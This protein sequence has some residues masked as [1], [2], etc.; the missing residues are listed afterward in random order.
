MKLHLLSTILLLLWVKAVAQDKSEVMLLATYHFANTSAD[1]YNTKVD[2]YLQPARQ[3][4]I[5]DVVNKLAQFKP[6]MIFIEASAS[7]FDH[8]N[9]KFKNY[10]SGAEKL[11]S[12]NEI[13][14]LG[15][16]LAKKMNHDAIY[17]VDAAGWWLQELVDA[18]RAEHPSESYNNYE[19]NREELHKL[20][21]ERYVKQTIGENFIEHNQ[22]E[23]ILDNHRY[24]VEVATKAIS[25]PMEGGYPMDMDS[26][27]LFYGVP[28]LYLGLNQ[29]NPGPEL[30][31]EWYKR[32]VRIFSNILHYTNLPDTNEERILV[33][34]GQ[35]HIRMLQQLFEDHS[36]FKL[37]NPLE[38]LEK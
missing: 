4:E 12:P 18:W 32:N 15:F 24:Y 14:Q 21:N 37:V 30:I 27:K 5:K 25:K 22:Q 10:S 29:D 31:G 34:F 1:T 2:D 3:A 19:K 33:I 11:D 7:K 28:H 35:G 16:R 9:E 13:Y 26:S 23:A 17:P 36:A 8:Y 20:R 6:T 38:Y